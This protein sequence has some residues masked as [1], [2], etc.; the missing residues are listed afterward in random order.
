MTPAEVNLKI[1]K[2]LMCGILRPYVT[3]PNRALE[4]LNTLHGAGWFWRLDSVHD[5]VICTLQ[6]KDR[7]TYSVRAPTVAGAICEAALRTLPS[8]S[9]SDGQKE[10]V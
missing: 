7:K 10:K 2:D 9:E 4:V 5:G 3:N 1:A 8:S 6:N